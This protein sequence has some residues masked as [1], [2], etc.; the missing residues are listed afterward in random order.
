MITIG[1][2][3]W[4][5]NQFGYS[6]SEYMRKLHAQI[7][8]ME[9]AEF[10]SR[11]ERRTVEA[12]VGLNY[13]IEIPN[14]DNSKGCSKCVITYKGVEENVIDSI[15]SVGMLK[16]KEVCHLDTF[17]VV[18]YDV[19]NELI[20]EA[21]RRF[22]TEQSV[23]L[24]VEKFDSLFTVNHIEATDI[25]QVTLDSILWQS[26]YRAMDK[27]FPPR[28]IVTYP[29][30][31]LMSQAMTAVVTVP[32]NPL[33]E[34]MMWQLAGSV[35]LVLVL[36]FCLVYQIKTILKQRKIDE[37]RK[38]FVNTMIHELKRPVQTLKMCVSFLNNKS[39]RAD[40][41]AMD[42]VL[43][44]SMF[45]L[46][47]LSAYLAKVRDMTRADYEHTPLNIRTFDVCEAIRKLVRLCN[48]PAGKHVVITPLF[49]MET[50]LVTADPVHLANIISNL[51]EN[52]IK[53]SGNEVT[54]RISCTLKENALTIVISDDG[55][56]IPSSEQDKVFCKFYRGSNI[57]D[58][59][60]PGIGLGLSYV[61]LL[62]EAHQ[63]T[64]TLMSQVGKGTT[65][66]LHFPQ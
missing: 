28:M 46:D 5:Y 58:R 36:C 47:N 35:L 12:L 65:F 66:T 56:G 44:D 13:S 6:A 52:A 50:S 33:L 60:T 4:I 32:V 21:I 38:G 25:Q 55:I 54:I 10:E 34:Q 20:F 61:K 63:G 27:I 18:T 48:V 42:E 1:Q 7:L 41:I 17:S 49:D 24:T 23:P 3:Y 2:V 26:T 14:S 22:S 51:L 9:N 19:S 16:K 30:N 45:E 62:T 40:E 43:K 37:L 11:Y 39:M 31:P 57:P 8:K 59:N 53:Y 15:D 29:Y 64:I